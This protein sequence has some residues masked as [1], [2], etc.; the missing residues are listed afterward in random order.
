MRKRIL[1]L[2]MCISF[3]LSPLSVFAT[4]TTTESTSGGSVT[5][6]DIMALGPDEEG[7]KRGKAYVAILRQEGYSDAAIAGILGNSV[8]ESQWNPLATEG[9]NGGL[10][11]FTPMTNFSNSDYNK[12]CKHTK[13]TA[14]GQSVC[15]DG[16]CQI[17]Y[18]MSC[19][20]SDMKV[21]SSR[22]TSY[23]K[24]VNSN[25]TESMS[26]S[27]QAQNVGWSGTKVIHNVPEGKSLDD[28]KK[29]TD[30]AGAMGVFILCYERAAGTYVPCGISPADTSPDAIVPGYDYTWRDFFL[31]EFTTEGTRVKSAIAVYEWISGKSYS[32]ADATQEMAQTANTLFESGIWDEDQLSSFC[33]LHEID[34][35]EELSKATKDN[36]NNNELVS[37]DDWKRQTEDESWYITWGRRIVMLV[38]IIMVV[39]S[40]L[41]YCGFWFDRINTFIDLD[42]VGILTLRKLKVSPDD[43][44]CTFKLSDLAKT[45]T[46][47]VNHKYCMIISVS[48][49]ALGVFMISGIMFTLIRK[50]VN[51]IVGFFTR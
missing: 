23:N 26:Y 46:R 29:A 16:S 11:G 9:S 20:E 49:L 33:K 41:F 19:L 21:Y 28:F 10:F 8:G 25:D 12:N 50:F 45:D 43:T 15:A 18:M 7:V 34:L 6:A 5:D 48:A 44:E 13:G 1:A 42:V 38:G 24:Y 30:P 36:L 22:C 35:S 40:L 2:V 27:S 31:H 4:D 17:A 47:T 14:G 37:L 3:I 39:W 51:L 32:D